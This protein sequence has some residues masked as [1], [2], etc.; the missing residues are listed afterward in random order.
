MLPTTEHWRILFVWLLSPR[1]QLMMHEAYRTERTLY[2]CLSSLTVRTAGAFGC[3]EI[4][5][6]S[7]KAPSVAPAPKN[8]S[9][10]TVRANFC[11]FSY[12]TRGTPQRNIQH[13]INRHTSP[14]EVNSQ[15]IKIQTHCRTN[16]M[17]SMHFNQS[18]RRSTH[19][20][21]RERKQRITMEQSIITLRSSFTVGQ[22]EQRKA[23][24]QQAT[25]EHIYE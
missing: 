3:I 1:P 19:R 12:Y 5:T 2:S 14:Y 25:N 6:V 11:I 4:R 18:T 16:R 9:Q 15:I 24:N 10:M 13:T 22:G 23:E 17:M 7:T 8:T 21:V 20:R